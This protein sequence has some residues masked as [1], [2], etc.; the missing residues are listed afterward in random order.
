MFEA[1]QPGSLVAIVAKGELATE[2]SADPNRF[3][4]S[5][6]EVGGVYFNTH[7]SVRELTR[8][9]RKIAIR[10][11]IVEADYEFVFE[12]DRPAN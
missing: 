6:A 2:L 10:L 8:R 3:H 9:L 12:H 7:A 5:K 4:R 1:T 11:G